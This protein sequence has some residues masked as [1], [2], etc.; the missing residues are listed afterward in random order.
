MQYLEKKQAT[1]ARITDKLE[2]KSVLKE[3]SDHLL[4]VIQRV[5]ELDVKGA[6][7]AHSLMGVFFLDVRRKRY[8]NREFNCNHPVPPLEEDVAKD[9]CGISRAIIARFEHL[10]FIESDVTNCSGC[11]SNYC[12]Y[13]QNVV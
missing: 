6:Q 7:E 11:I 12:V 4:V 5:L 8:L 3:L 1:L 2:S 9:F 10:F 13:N